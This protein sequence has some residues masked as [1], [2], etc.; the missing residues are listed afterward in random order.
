[1]ARARS[2]DGSRREEAA[3]ATRR[4]IVDAARALLLDGGYAAM[5]VT[6]LAERA[7]VS[8][9]TVYNSV[10]GK[11]AVVKAVYDTTL[12]GDDDPVPMSERPA[13]VAMRESADAAGFLRAYAAWSRG[14]YERVGPLLSVLLFDGVGD[15]ATL[16]DLAATIERER[17]TGNGHAVD[18]LRRTHG[19][20]RGLTRER[21][22]DAVWTLTAP[23]VADRLVRRCGWSGT[24]YERWL[25]SQLVAALC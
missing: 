24:A 3:R 5:T 10:G 11:A 8:P 1:V 18:L 9:Q 20:R 13:F 21:A 6:V 7:G 25:A 16:R 12:A 14:I 23:E 19:L 15:D 22:V 4:R 17:R 2:Y